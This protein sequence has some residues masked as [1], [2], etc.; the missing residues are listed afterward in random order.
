MKHIFYHRSMFLKK[1]IMHVPF[2]SIYNKDNILNKDMY[3]P[4]EKEQL[5][6][7]IKNYMQD[8][9]KNISEEEKARLLE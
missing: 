8:D 1:Q 7:Y 9:P 5:E 6:A 3:K 2:R 4:S